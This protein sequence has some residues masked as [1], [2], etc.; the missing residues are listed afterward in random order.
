MTPSL[1]AALTGRRIETL[2]C[3]PEPLLDLSDGLLIRI[4]GDFRLAGPRGVEHYYPG[5]VTHPTGGLKRLPGSLITEAGTTLAGA[6]VLTLDSGL[7]LTVPPDS[8]DRP[9]QVAN[10]AGPLFTAL[11]GGYTT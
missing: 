6:L 1:S 4:A 10:P 9:W 8:T 3:G 5:L 7:T 2:R 11:P